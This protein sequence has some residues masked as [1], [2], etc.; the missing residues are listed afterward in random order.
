MNFVTQQA[1]RAF[2][3]V[4][5][6]INTPGV[7]SWIQPALNAVLASLF[8]TVFYCLYHGIGGWLMW[9][10]A[11]LTCGLAFSANVVLTEVMA[12]QAQQ[13]KQGIIDGTESEPE[14]EEGGEP[15]EDAGQGDAAE[16]ECRDKDKDA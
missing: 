12:I 7:Q 9:I 2:Q 14:V 3:A 15:L 13:G 8:S 1:E 4:W 6:S 5:H 10:M 16:G 11:L